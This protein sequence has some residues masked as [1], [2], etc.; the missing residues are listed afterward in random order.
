MPA[1]QRSVRS[2][3]PKWPGAALVAVLSL[4]LAAPAPAQVSKATRVVKARQA[5]GE[6]VKALFTAKGL[7]YPAPR[8]FLRAFKHE[9]QLEL[10]AGKKGEPLVLIKTFAICSKSGELGPKRRRGD[11]QVPEGFYR[12]N[13]FQPWSN[14]HLSLKVNYPNDSDRKLGYRRDPGGD[15]FIHGACVTIGCLPL[16]DGPIEELF[17][18]VLDTHNAGG[19]PIPV[20]I[21]PTRMDEAGMA[22]LAKLAAD[23]APHLAFWNNL[24]PG[25]EAFERTRKVPKVW[26]EPESGRYRFK[27]VE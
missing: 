4:A 24:K 14:F 19:R 12:I 11:L 5:R 22:R 13:H 6:Q 27:A 23:G 25:Y 10:W 21:F 3:R 15:I 2:S 20:H 1:M 7:T 8:L 17:L 16:E 9:D 26:I 18:A